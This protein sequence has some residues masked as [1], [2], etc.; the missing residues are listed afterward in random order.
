[1]KEIHGNHGNISHG[2]PDERRPNGLKTQL[3]GGISDIIIDFH[4]THHPAPPAKSAGQIM[5][6]LRNISP[7]VSPAGDSRI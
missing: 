2:E 7:L 6:Q 4:P 1:V 5:Q 3:K